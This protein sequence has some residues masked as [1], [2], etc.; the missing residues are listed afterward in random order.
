MLTMNEFVKTMVPEV[1]SF[2]DEFGVLPKLFWSPRG[3]GVALV[4]HEC[5]Y[6]INEDTPVWDSVGFPCSSSIVDT[7][8]QGSVVV[9]TGERTMGFIRIK[10]QTQSF[11][12]W[13]FV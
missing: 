2:V 8:K 1:N 7:V 12:L 10:P 9:G 13:L 3:C 11:V 5:M 6:S 4:L